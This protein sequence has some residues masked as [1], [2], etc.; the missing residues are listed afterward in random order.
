[1]DTARVKTVQ[2]LGKNQA[3]HVHTIFVVEGKELGTFI[4]AYVDTVADE[5]LL[6]GGKVQR[7][8]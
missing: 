6:E 5:R 2:R 1:M 4:I 8:M 3:S 7:G